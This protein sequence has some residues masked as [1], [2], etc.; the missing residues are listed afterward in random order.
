MVLRLYGFM[1]YGFTVVWF[2][3]FMVLLL[4]GFTGLYFYGFMVVWFQ[5][6]H[7]SSISCFLIDIDPI[8]MIFEILFNGRSPLFGARLFQNR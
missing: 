3:G 4:Y 7:K 2:Y 5:E 8:S 1:V 6:V